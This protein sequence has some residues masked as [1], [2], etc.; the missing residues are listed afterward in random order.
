MPFN[1]RAANALHLPL[2]RGRKSA[3]ASR[4]R[5]RSTRFGMNQYVSDYHKCSS[6]RER[7]FHEPRRM[8]ISGA[9]DHSLLTASRTTHVKIVVVALLGAILVVS[10]GIA[11]HV[12][13]T[14]SAVLAPT[15]VKA[16]QPATFTKD[17]R[18]L[19]R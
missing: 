5:Y 1:N 15:V 14:P 17:N 11:A 4:R 10:I 3:I 12:G 13:G 8:P 2:A 9:M 7:R 18:T 16:G 19:A 6:P